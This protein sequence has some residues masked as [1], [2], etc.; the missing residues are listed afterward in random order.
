MQ[1]GGSQKSCK[2]LTETQL[3]KNTGDGKNIEKD[4]YKPRKLHDRNGIRFWDHLGFPSWKKLV[5]L[6][7][8][9]NFN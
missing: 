6:A 8:W 7:P 1:K 3:N 4:N 5:V 9:F 2:N